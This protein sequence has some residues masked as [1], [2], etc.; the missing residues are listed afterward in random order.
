MQES[1]RAYIRAVAAA[2]AEA[3]ITVT[4]VDFLDDVWDD[5]DP[6][7]CAQLIVSNTSTM[8]VYGVPTVLLAWTEEWGWFLPLAPSLCDQAV[9]SPA[10]VV[11][12]V[13]AAFGELPAQTKPRR[14][15]RRYTDYDDAFETQ[16]DAYTTQEQQRTS[17]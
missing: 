9:P 8:R 12:T 5:G 13:Q 10:E 16:L 3:G 1:H 4:D 7:R 11:S 17:A 2:L 6:I 15:Y 14:A